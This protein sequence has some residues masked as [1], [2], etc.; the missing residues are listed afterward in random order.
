MPRIT[1]R[2]VPAGAVDCGGAWAAQLSLCCFAIVEIPMVARVASAMGGMRELSGAGF[3][4]TPRTKVR[5]R[6]LGRLGVLVASAGGYCARGV[7]I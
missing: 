7:E 4:N 3:R 6:F 1:A 5:R 2:G